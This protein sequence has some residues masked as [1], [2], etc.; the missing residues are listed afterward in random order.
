MGE[1]ESPQ[2]LHPLC[3]FLKSLGHR[4]AVP[5]LVEGQV[6]PK[7]SEVVDDL[8]V[9][10]GSGVAGTGSAWVASTDAR[11]RRPPVRSG[12]HPL[13]VRSAGAMVGGAGLGKLC[14]GCVRGCVWLEGCGSICPCKGAKPSSSGWA[15]RCD[16]AFVVGN[17]GP[18]VSKVLPR[19]DHACDCCCSMP[20]S[21]SIE[22]EI[23][24]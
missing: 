19:K 5:R 1:W 7:V 17:F 16:K 11:G 15:G 22:E 20:C 8:Y 12:N 24:C 21:A 4:S 2:G 3:C 10:A 18:E 6:S 9:Y 13:G 23:I 14:C